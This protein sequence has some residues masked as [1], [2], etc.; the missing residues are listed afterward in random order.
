VA[1]EKAGD[2]GRHATRLR[3]RLRD[4]I[5]SRYIGHADAVRATLASDPQVDAALETLADG[6]RLRRVLGG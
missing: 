3:V 5:L 2:F 1:R 6:A 4:E